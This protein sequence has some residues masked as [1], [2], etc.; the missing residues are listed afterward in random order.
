MEVERRT[1]LWLR[2]SE[3]IRGHLW[4][5]YSV[6]VNQV[7]VATIQEE[8]EDT[9][10]YSESGYRR[11]TDNTMAR[12]KSSKGQTTIYKAYTKNKKSSNT[13]PTKN[14]G[15]SGRVSSSCSTS[16]TRRVNL[17]THQVIS[18]KWENDRKVLKTSGT[19]PWS[20]VT[21]IFHNGQL[22]HG[23]DRKA[24]EEMISI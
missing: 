21:Q 6:E 4:H 5:R 20:F 18:H 24:F 14:A 19:Y 3:H 15:Y 22:S 12:T 11:R 16:G 2:Q 9:I 10:G 17:V 7:I 13:N 23:G 1:G 8:F